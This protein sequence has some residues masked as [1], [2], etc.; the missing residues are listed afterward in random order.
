MG[1]LIKDYHT[2]LT[3]IAERPRAKP[4]VE[5]RRAI[6]KNFQGHV[7]LVAVSAE[8]IGEAESM[9]TTPDSKD[10]IDRMLGYCAHAGDTMAAAYNIGGRPQTS[11]AAESV[12]STQA[13]PASTPDAEDAEGSNMPTAQH[14][15]QRTSDN[16]KVKKM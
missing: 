10:E 1:H 5:G 3:W 9:P 15:D 6:V 4:S 13:D 7:D 2:G 14:L 12:R 8:S 11:A 16:A